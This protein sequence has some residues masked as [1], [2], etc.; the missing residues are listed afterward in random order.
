[1]FCYF[2]PQGMWG[3]APDRGIEPALHWKAKVDANHWL[4][5]SRI[6]IFTKPG[7]SYVLHGDP[8]S[9]M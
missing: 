5:G 9:I 3:L 6:C 2:G 8:C 1:M 4:P 7:L